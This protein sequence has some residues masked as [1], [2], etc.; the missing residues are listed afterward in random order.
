MTSFGKPD[1]QQGGRLAPRSN[2]L[3]RVWM[4]GSF[5]EPKRKKNEEL[6]SKRRLERE[7]Q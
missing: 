1:D 5:I 4:P 7:R 2:H 3:V 6:R